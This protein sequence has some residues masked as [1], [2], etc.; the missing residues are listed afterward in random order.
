MFIKKYG[1]STILALILVASTG[2]EKLLH[3]E[4]PSPPPA[5][6]KLG[7]ETQCLSNTLPVAEKFMQGEANLEEVDAAWGC[8]GYAIDAFSRKVKSGTG[9]NT[10]QARELARFFEDFFLNGDRI[11]DSLLKEIMHLKVMFFGGS[12]SS[13]TRAELRRVIEFSELMKKNSRIIGPYMKVFSMNWRTQG[14]RTLDKDIKYFED[15]NQAIQQV[16]NNLAEVIESNGQSYTLSN[17]IILLKEIEALY[18]AH[19]PGLDRYAQ[20]MPLVQE[21]KKALSGGEGESIQPTE[22]RRFALL[23]SRGFVQYLR[24]YYFVDKADESSG[25]TQLIFLSSSAEDFF[26]YLGEMVKGKKDSRLTPDEIFSLAER[27]RAVFPNFSLSK[28]LITELMK[29]KQVLFGGSV[30]EFTP[31]DFENAKSKVKVLR[32]ITERVLGFAELYSYKWHPN[33]MSEEDAHFYFDEGDR[34]LKD[35]GQLFALLTEAPYDLQ[36][37]NT[38]AEEIKKLYPEAKDQLDFASTLQMYLP[39]MIEGKKMAANDQSSIV[40]LEQW[41]PIFELVSR[42][43]GRSLYYWYF[44]QSRSVTSGPGLI[45]M[46]DFVNQSLDIVET[47]VKKRTQMSLAI[48]S[49]VVSAKDVE[50]LI[51]ALYNV[52]LIPKTYR[53]DIILPVYKLLYERFFLD[54]QVRLRGEIPAGMNLATIKIMRSEL[55]YWFENQIFID[56]IFLASPA[57]EGIDHNEVLTKFLKVPATPAKNEMI[58]IL[59]SRMPFILDEKGRIFLGSRKLQQRLYSLTVLNSMRSI[60]RLLIGAYA[61]DYK[62]IESGVGLTIDELD[63]LFKDVLY[64]GVELDMLDPNKLNFAKSRFIEGNLFTPHSNGDDFLSFTELSDLA[65]M[66]YSGTQVNTPIIE[67]AKKECQIKSASRFSATQVP[68]PCL[69]QIYRRDLP[70]VFDSAPDLVSFEAGLSAEQYQKLM[71][72]FLDAAGADNVSTGWITVSD[73]GLLPHVMQYAEAL[74]Q[75]YDKDRSGTLSKEEGLDAFPV[76]QQMIQKMSGFDNDRINRGVFTYMLKFGHA[77]E[78]FSEKVYLFVRWLPEEE[79]WDINTDRALLVDLFG[80]ISRKIS[81]PAPKGDQP[82]N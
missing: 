27:V 16:A 30:T 40:R 82:K 38:L 25:S 39:V 58:A 5:N 50:P 71:L 54:P 12:E 34:I 22:W 17:S 29:I 2:C 81:E 55:A 49:S 4:P 26:S 68:V 53:P 80:Y 56:A 74:M 48:G 14:Y 41:A 57:G 69:L 31:T 33:E 19:W 79:H 59:N 1:I 44:V 21:L 28:A 15:A 77:P 8:F 23:A 45:S 36:N 61:Q 76:F 47:I 32:K 35:V 18:G 73:A 24:Y 10:F 7:F 65:T 46:R 62:R 9:Q 3:E 75:N 72:N 52:K 60:S 20:L 11:S 6:T 42:L 43:Y 78:T 67:R 63:K 66:I 64:V 13:L 37:L 70:E 51:K